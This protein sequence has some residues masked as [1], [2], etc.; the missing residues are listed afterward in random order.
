MALHLEAPGPTTTGDEM[1]GKCSASLYAG[2]AIAVL[3]SACGGSDSP[4]FAS[5]P[6]EPE[7]K[8][9][10]QAACD[11]LAGMSIPASAIGLPTSG[12]TVTTAVLTAP[13]GTGAAAIPEYCRVTGTVA[14]VDPTAPS[15]TFRVALP[16]VW[17]LKAVMFGG[18]GFSGSIPNVAGNVPAG[19]S[20]QLTPLGRG[21]ATFG[22]DSGHQA[23]AAGSLDGQFLLNDEAM[24]NWGGN[25]LKKTRDA[26]IFLIK[27]RYAK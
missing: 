27:A 25:A 6:A 20:D 1:K 2:C 13:S 11:E 16:T 17:N 14:P 19:P 22:S 18:G 21:Y 15:I 9:T 4:D 26:A 24:R 3:L 8:P 5:T 7:R 10:P 12:G 23:N